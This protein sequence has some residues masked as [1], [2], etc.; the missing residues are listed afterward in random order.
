MLQN[1]EYAKS[2]WLVHFKMV[3]CM[4]GEFYFNKAVFKIWSIF[5]RHTYSSYLTCLL[6]RTWKGIQIYSSLSIILSLYLLC[7]IFSWTLQKNICSY[8]P[9]T[10]LLAKAL[11]CVNKLSITHS[12][13]E[14]HPLHK[15]EGSR[16]VWKLQDICWLT[17]ERNLDTLPHKNFYP[18]VFVYVEAWY[19][20]HLML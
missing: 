7:H 19:N 10:S 5:N 13:R 12:E 17:W 4:T 20:T 14:M 6:Q 15:I 3:T 2:H 16:E 18:Y 8:S 11:H 1:C 9:T